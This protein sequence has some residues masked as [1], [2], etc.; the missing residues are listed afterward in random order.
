MDY[1]YSSEYEP[2]NMPFFMPPT[3][4]TYPPQQFDTA[5]SSAQNYHINQAEIMDLDEFNCIADYY[6][7]DQINPIYQAAPLPYEQQFIPDTRF[8]ASVFGQVDYT[9]SD[10]QHLPHWESD[11]S[12]HGELA[13]MSLYAHGSSLAPQMAVPVPTSFR[14]PLNRMIEPEE[15]ELR[16]EDIRKIYIIENHTLEETIEI[17]RKRF[18]FS[19]KPAIYKNHFAKWGPAFMKNRT[20]KN[21]RTIVDEEQRQDRRRKPSKEAHPPQIAST[22]HPTGGTL[23]NALI[24]EAPTEDFVNSIREFL[25]KAFAPGE[26]MWCINTFRLQCLSTSVTPTT[27]WELLFHHS[28]EASILS[29]AGWNKNLKFIIGNILS[30]T[31]VLLLSE[32]PPFERHDPHAL[33]YFIRIL[34]EFYRMRRRGRQRLEV[35]RQE[36]LETFLDITSSSATTLLIN[37]PLLRFIEFIRKKLKSYREETIQ[38]LE[39]SNGLQSMPDRSVEFLSWC[40]SNILQTFSHHINPYH[41]V[42]LNITAYHQSVWKQA[43]INPYPSLHAEYTLLLQHAKNLNPSSEEAI[44]LWLDFV[45][46]STDNHQWPNFKL[47]EQMKNLRYHSACWIHRQK[48]L[49]LQPPTYAFVFTTQWL[50]N[51]AYKF[52]KDTC[53]SS[54]EYLE[55]GIEV[56]RRGDHDCCIWA[57]SFSKR[58]KL[59]YKGCNQKGKCAEKFER[60]IRR[61]R[62]ITKDLHHTSVLKSPLL[63]N[64]GESKRK[65][66]TKRRRKEEVQVFKIV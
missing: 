37:H 8:S 40:H 56:L 1:E 47:V 61:L 6:G 43:Y 42:A 7:T 50:A 11:P 51:K 14:Q 53:V 2:G 9:Q 12:V 33:I 36:L 63:K 48:Q 29:R 15:W 32:S 54:Y 34:M 25:G 58:M 31:K 45:I 38:S 23:R 22:I 49:R 65:F 55:K 17:M 30:S 13:H 26:R 66:R 10:V 19:S 20:E 35:N 27:S 5:E 4:F 21:G 44:A 28:Q 39:L 24:P 18:A 46:M 64:A 57:A 52:P 62:D 59:W 41:A 16:K 60:E 3:A